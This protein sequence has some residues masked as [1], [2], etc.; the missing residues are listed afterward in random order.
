MLVMS[1]GR[2]YGI[3][4]NIIRPTNNYG[5]HQYPEK[6]IPKTTWRM[7]RGLPATLHGDG[8][9][10]RSWLHVEDTVEAV[11]TVIDRG[12]RN[13]IY[14]AGGNK[15]LRNIEIVREIARIIGIVE[16]KAYVSVADRSGQ[17]VRYSLDDTKL[18][19]LGW[20]ASRRLSEEL[21]SIVAGLDASR[22]R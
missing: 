6:L 13:E 19:T 16:E 9:Y 18:K 7:K 17:D 3:A 15:E 14:N 8:S 21:A 22:F 10:K 2:T 4:W 1:W 11:L 5:P 20:N 12:K